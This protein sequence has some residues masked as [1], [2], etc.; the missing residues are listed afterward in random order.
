MSRETENALL[1][2]LGLAT[3]I[4]TVTGVYTRYVKRLFCRGWPRSRYCASCW[5]STRS[6]ATYAAGAT[7]TPGAT[8]TPARAAGG[9]GRGS[10]S[11]HPFPQRITPTLSGAAGRART[12]SLA[13][14]SNETGRARFRGYLEL[15][16]DHHRRVHAQSRWRNRSGTDHDLLLRRRH[17][18]RA[19]ASSARRRPQSYPDNTWI[20]VEGTV[21]P[22]GDAASPR[23]PH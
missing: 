22:P 13:E 5:P 10:H 11:D 17:T 16:A 18:A 2:L 3:A 15:A 19:P 6:S 7:T 20:N 14:E 23:F 8:C 21:A 12:G 9:A 1:L 4:I